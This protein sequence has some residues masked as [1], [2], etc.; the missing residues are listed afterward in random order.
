MFSPNFHF[1]F[2]LRIPNFQLL[3]VIDLKF[4]KK[5]SNNLNKTIVSLFYIY[6]FNKSHVLAYISYNQLK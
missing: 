6:G 5:Y 4:V 2:F 3:T 1:F